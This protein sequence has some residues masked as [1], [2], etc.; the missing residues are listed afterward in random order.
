MST[1]LD[2]SSLSA[3]LGGRPKNLLIGGEWVPASS[4]RTLD[5]INPST[6]EVI[7]QIAEGDAEDVDRAVKAARKA[8]EG[9]WRKFKPVQRQNVLLKLA[10]LLEEHA[11]EL[12]LLDVVDMGAP[13]ARS[14]GAAYAAEGLR[15]WA[16]WA[17]KLH[18]ETIPNSVPGSFF[19]YT[20][21]EPVGVVGAIIPWN[22][23]L[24]MAA[25]KLAPAL[26]TGCTVVLKPAEQASLSPLRLGE[27]IQ[28]LDLPDGVVNI[29]TGFGET[30][31][32]ALSGHSDVDKIAFTGS[33]VTG[34]EIVRAAAG[35]LKRVSL[36][37]GGKS[38]DIIFAD[39]DMDAAV[40]G[41]AMGVF[42]NT[43]QMCYAGSRVFVERPIYEEFVDRFAAFA[44]SL[45][46]GNSL[47]PTTQLG[48]IVSQGQLD[49]VTGYLEV[50]K[51]AG[52]TVA[53][54]GDR[55]DAGELAK[56]YFVAPTVFSDV[57][58]DMRIAQEEIFGPVASVMP[59]DDVDEVIRRA[60]STKF[61]LAAG[62]WTC[63][64]GKAHRLAQAI[65]TGVVWVNTY[66]V[67]AASMPFGGSKMSGWGNEGSEHGLREYLNIKSVWIKTDA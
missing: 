38:P 6:G 62:V 67:N 19:S 58:D 51:A 53:A 10:A 27:L 46:V 28:E 3:S 35:N 18:G 26:T 42:G 13:I 21:A 52:A 20:L 64:V 66:A 56:G 8:F 39:S 11:E 14:G 65:D 1:V 7:A 22:G 32:A 5:S 2:P 23:P 15:Y 57:H 40:P 44:D 29:V 12:G 63:D 59:F 49:R 31:G 16:G 54:G 34:Q 37:L 55:L 9:P 17:T 45:T 60:N 47:D 41:A 25:L 30:A 48:P 50:G 24:P 43:G 33:S 36:E 4:G 61:G